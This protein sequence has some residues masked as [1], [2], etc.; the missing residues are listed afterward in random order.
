MQQIARLALWMEMCFFR[1]VWVFH[2]RIWKSNVILFVEE[3]THHIEWWTGFQG[4]V[5]SFSVL[6]LLLFGYV[7]FWP[8]FFFFF[9][10]WE[11]CSMNCLC[12][13]HGRMLCFFLR[14]RAWPCKQGSGS[15]ADCLTNSAPH[16]GLF[17]YCTTERYIWF[18]AYASDITDS[19]LLNSL[20][21]CLSNARRFFKASFTIWSRSDTKNFQTSYLK[22]VP[23]K[24]REERKG[25]KIK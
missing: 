13:L 3:S 10:W 9:N 25:K 12:Y 20:S 1:S 4:F 15:N 18:A 14:N 16:L 11:G 22:G 2:W 6:F 21:R 7:W 19:A 24:K 23:K 17:I 8:R 5:C